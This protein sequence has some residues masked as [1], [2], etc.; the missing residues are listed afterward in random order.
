MS[1]S[2]HRPRGL[3]QERGWRPQHSPL[4]VKAR[5]EPLMGEDTRPEAPHPETGSDLEL[6][7]TLWVGGVARGSC[8][9]CHLLW[10]R[11]TWRSPPPEG[12]DFLSPVHTEKCCFEG[13]KLLKQS[14]QQTKLD[15]LLVSWVVGSSSCCAP[16]GEMG[17]AWEWWSL[18]FCTNTLC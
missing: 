12:W 15:T 13:S 1:R 9:W 10:R 8:Q 6:G 5:R 17:F 2:V 14:M 11:D 16:C 3:L 4:R 18:C 7:S